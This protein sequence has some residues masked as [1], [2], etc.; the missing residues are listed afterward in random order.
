M[1]LDWAEG[2]SCPGGLPCLLGI[3]QAKKRR[4][5][6]FDTCKTLTSLPENAFV[7][8]KWL[9]D[10]RGKNRLCAKLR[11]YKHCVS[12]PLCAKTVLS[13]PAGVTF[14]LPSIS[15]LFGANKGFPMFQL[16]HNTARTPKHHFRPRNRGLGPQPLLPWC[17]NCYNYVVCCNFS[18]GSGLHCLKLQYSHSKTKIFMNIFFLLF[19]F[20]FQFL[21]G[22]P[23]LTASLF[24]ADGAKFAC[25]SWVGSQI[26][27]R[28]TIKI[29]FLHLFVDARFRVW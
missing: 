5:E 18:Q 12:K 24:W 16:I 14:Q 7:C 21:T 10:E 17:A 19:L 6:E 1:F 3:A 27:S 26:W 13:W 15:S 8:L 11:L 25:L 23:S 4:L 29:H 22:D 2:F 9:R 28:K 20:V